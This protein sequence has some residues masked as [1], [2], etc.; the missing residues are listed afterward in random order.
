MVRST[1]HSHMTHSLKCWARFTEAH[2][3]IHFSV[4]YTQ[5]KAAKMMCGGT[6]DAKPA[7]PEVQNICDSVKS[8][9]EEK[10]GKKY[11]TFQV[12]SYKTQVV[13][14][15]NYFVKVHVGGEDHVHLRIHK[16][17]PHTGGE[18]KVS[19]FQESKSHH[20]PIDYFN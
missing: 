19:S 4:D 2:T 10:T 15:T 12:K 9:V 16:G 6:T 7:D 17:L 20:D 8:K 13:A 5:S 14:G 18:L 11:D 1:K 3:L